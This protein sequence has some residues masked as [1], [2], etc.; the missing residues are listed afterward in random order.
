MIESRK[1]GGVALISILTIGATSIIFL[2]ALASIITSAVRANSSNKWAESVR[3]AAEIGIDYA[4]DQFNTTYPCP[5][6]AEVTAFPAIKT[7]QVPSSAFT[8]EAIDGLIPTIGVP[9]ITVSLTVT[10]ITSKDDWNYLSNHSSV[11]SPQLDPNKSINSGWESPP[12]SNLSQDSGGGFR[13]LESVATNGVI[14]KKIRVILRAHFEPPP[15]GVGPD[16]SG[17]SPQ[18]YF[19]K[20]LFANKVLTLAPSSGELNVQSTGVPVTDKAYNLTLSA[21]QKTTMSNNAKVFGNVVVSSGGPKSSASFSIGETNS[22]V[23]GTLTTNGNY[24]SVKV[25][26]G[27]NPSPGDNVLADAETP[28]TTAQ[29]LVPAVKEASISQNQIAPVQQPTIASSLGPLKSVD[30]SL[31]G[32]YTTSNLSSDGVTTPVTL[33]N[34]PAR[35]FVQDSNSNSAVNVDSNA[36]SFTNFGK[37]EPRNLQ[38]WYEGTKPITVNLIPDHQFSGVIYAPNATVNV[39][40]SGDFTGG[41]VGKDVNILMSGNLKI[42]PTLGDASKQSGVSDKNKYGLSYQ[43]NSNGSI[44]TGWQPVVWQEMKP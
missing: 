28:R 24:S 13:V 36:F 17:S 7:T 15:D 29:N 11:Y 33:T 23:H 39:T 19:T 35:I 20:P 27:P 34:D 18:S 4:V 42:D 26:N 37:A 43:K 14:S 16:T 3:N 2:M 10:R 31:S 38:I 9:N 21:N 8:S 12:E 5:L 22:F 32:D 30:G 40:G 6:D 25:T 44:I 1:Q 41:I